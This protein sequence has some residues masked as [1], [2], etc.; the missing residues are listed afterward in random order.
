MS[1]STRPHFRS[2]L[3]LLL[4]LLTL[5]ADRTPAQ[6]EPSQ[7]TL[8]Q[9]RQARKEAV[10][11]RRRVILNNDGCDVLYFPADREITPENLL[12]LRTSPLV[13]SHVDTI[14]YCTISSGFGYFTH[15]TKVGSV[16]DTDVAGQ[17][18]RNDVNATRPLI[19]QG[20]DALKV[21]VDFC[22]AHGIEI[23]WSMR[24]NDTHDAGHR[25]DR[26]Y[27][28]FSPVKQKHPEYLIG[29][30]EDRPKH[31]AWTAV[32][33]THPAIRD[34]A[35][36]YIREVCR[37]YDV[38]G[39]ELDFFRHL[40]YFK[41]VA[42]GGR[43]T[44]E[45]LDMMTDLIRR[46]RE[47]TEREGMRRG[48]PIL[49][50]VR[51]PD[52]VG[53]CRAMGF[54]LPR[55]LSE[56]LVDLLIGTCYFQLNPWEHLV[57]LGHRHNVKVYPGLSESRLRGETA[58]LRRNSQESY[59]GRALRA[60]QSGADGV[61]LFN[62]FHPRAPMLHEIGDP[63]L[64]GSLDKTYF[65]TLRPT[66]RRSYGNPAYWLTGGEQFSNVPIL[67]PEDPLHLKPG[68]P[69]TV[70]LLVG[71]DLAAAV[72]RGL[73]PTAVCQ[74]V[75]AGGDSVTVTLN[76]TV[77]E[78][79]R[80]QGAIVEFPLQPE[81]L[82]PGA[83]TIQL[84]YLPPPPSAAAD[85]WSAEW[86]ATALPASSWR[87]DALRPEIT[88]A[89]LQDGALLI[90]DRGTAAGEYLYYA[91]PWSADAEEMTLV[92][93]EVKVVSGWNNVI[94]CN[95]RATERLMLY[96]DYIGTYHSRLRYDMDTT[97]DFHTYRIEL[98]G[99]DLRVYVDGQLRLDATG[100]FTAPS[101]GRNEL[102]FG[103]ANSPS[104]GEALWRTVR[105]RTSG[106][107]TVED[108]AVA[109]RFRQQQE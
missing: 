14:F 68:E 49:L 35:F 78:D 2:V 94:V 106:G 32:D 43:A 101:D 38:D 19:E 83:N 60:W 102:R 75:A 31:A 92:E 34:L 103:A 24:M 69:V 65:V 84:Q 53:Y 13:G 41:T 23:F 36:G 39:I 21:M 42:A 82:H 108:L 90:A 100:R 58:P 20:T 5:S 73:R 62:F 22:R 11:R 55:W 15:D 91:Y 99:S 3:F 93:A 63:D 27:P 70:Q 74:M 8:E 109:V 26:P 46:V 56:G 45:E 105:L 17:F 1:S 71:D 107:A 10:E 57:E 28:L 54:D 25:P 16:L 52:S 86:T 81:W 12:E 104:V 6:V 33:Y 44:E 98:T 47:M 59:R 18:G 64:L 88:I 97:G 85:D 89:Q 76:G 9:L 40:S 87:H 72:E 29:S 96:P 66:R 61:Y 37:N 30:M 51:V 77:L 67:S 95:G 48:R 80:S 79:R 4:A 50:A 7:L